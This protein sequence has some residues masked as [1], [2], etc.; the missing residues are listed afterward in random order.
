MEVEEHNSPIFLVDS[1]SYRR[2]AKAARK[3][4]IEQR[5]HAV[6]SLD[7]AMARAEQQLARLR[8]MRSQLM[9]AHAVG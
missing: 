1:P 7:V 6:S 5:G 4:T 8:E 9:H 3:A 2:Q